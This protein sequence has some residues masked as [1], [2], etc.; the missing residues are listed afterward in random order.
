MKVNINVQDMQKKISFVDS[1]KLYIMNQMIS[2]VNA[3]KH[4][5]EVEHIPIL[6][7]GNENQYLERDIEGTQE[8]TIEGIKIHKNSKNEERRRINNTMR[9]SNMMSYIVL[10]TI[11]QQKD[12]MRRIERKYY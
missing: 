3:V 12:T 10:K 4:N 5:L 1:A 6:K 8:T 2:F 11:G 9:R 7:V